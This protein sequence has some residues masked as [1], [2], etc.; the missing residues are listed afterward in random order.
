M[1][2]RGCQTDHFLTRNRILLI[3]NVNKTDRARR[4]P[5]QSRGGGGSS[6]DTPVEVID[7]DS[8]ACYSQATQHMVASFYH[9][10]K[11]HTLDFGSGHDLRVV[12]LRL[13]AGH[14]G[15][16]TCLRFFSFSLTFCSSPPLALSLSF[17]NKKQH[18]QNKTKSK[19]P[20]GAP[21]WYSWL[22]LTL[23]FSSGHGSRGP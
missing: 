6:G 4:S 2:G 8:G 18:I 10:I 20:F 19:F 11:F 23:G 3:L 7:P 12:R 21:G 22:A 16:G 15:C 1:S 17:K 5:R 14:T 9:W 13:H